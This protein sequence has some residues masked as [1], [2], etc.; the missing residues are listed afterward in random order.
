MPQEKP[1]NPF[2]TNIDEYIPIYCIVSDIREWCTRRNNLPFLVTNRSE[3][4]TKPNKISTNN[5]QVPVSEEILSIISHSTI[6][7]NLNTLLK[8]I[9]ISTTLWLAI[10][11]TI[12]IE[13]D[14]AIITKVW[15]CSTTTLSARDNTMNSSNSFSDRR[16]WPGHRK[17]I[18][19]TAWTKV[20][21]N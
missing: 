2:K 13:T 5:P 15:E 7:A 6:R 9:R 3:A 11:D 1:K 8:I 18:P 14:R 4:T 19:T 17:T 10:T 12:R 16:I 20:V 21:L